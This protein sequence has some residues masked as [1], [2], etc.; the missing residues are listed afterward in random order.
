[1]CAAS[2][3]SSPGALQR[4]QPGALLIRALGAKGEN[5]HIHI[6]AWG[7]Q[8]MAMNKGEGL[9]IQ[10]WWTL[11]LSKQKSRGLGERT[12]GVTLEDTVGFLVLTP[13]DCG[14]REV[15]AGP[16]HSGY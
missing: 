3:W 11:K 9:N 15:W 12:C 5:G 16:G 4:I 8:K 1:M 7:H 6:V 14:L 2:T 13:W 10:E